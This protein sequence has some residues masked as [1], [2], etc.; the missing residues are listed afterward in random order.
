MSSKPFSRIQGTDVRLG[1]A[2][3]EMFRQEVANGT[4]NVLVTVTSSF[5]YKVLFQKAVLYYYKYECY[6]PFPVP[7]GGVPQ[8]VSTPGIACARSRN[9]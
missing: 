6:L 7:H 2:A 4:F 8:A 1:P 3:A 5:M 9:D